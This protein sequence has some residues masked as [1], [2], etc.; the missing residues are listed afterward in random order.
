MNKKAD[1]KTEFIGLR[2]PQKLLSRLDAVA[3][4]KAKDAKVDPNVSNIVTQCLAAHLPVL[5]AQYGVNSP[6]EDD[7][8]G[9]LDAWQSDRKRRSGSQRKGEAPAP[10]DQTQRQRPAGARQSNGKPTSQE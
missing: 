9:V 5:E 7:A 10:N 2:I 1:K 6:A 8:E 3:V 4:A